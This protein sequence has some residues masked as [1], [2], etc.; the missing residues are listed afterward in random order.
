MLVFKLRLMR[1]NKKNVRDE[2]YDFISRRNGLVRT[3]PESD[4]GASVVEI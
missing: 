2:E 3:E 4:T 1:F